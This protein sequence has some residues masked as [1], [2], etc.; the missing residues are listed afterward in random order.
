MPGL[1]PDLDGM[2]AALPMFRA[3]LSDF[4]SEFRDAASEGELVAYRV[5]WSGTHTGDFMGIPATGKRLTVTETH[6]DRV[7]D[8]K[9]IE[10]GG[11]W[12]QLGLL[13][14]IGAVPAAQ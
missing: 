3:A 10:H 9:I 12:D 13:Q 1:P 5:T 14:Q 7:R 11:D 8:G 2:L 4:E 6:F